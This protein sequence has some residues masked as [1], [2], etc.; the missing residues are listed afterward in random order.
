M[1]TAKDIKREQEIIHMN[2]NDIVEDIINKIEKHIQQSTDTYI[3]ID[4]IYHKDEVFEK[5]KELGF[6]IEDKSYLFEDDNSID[7]D[8]FYVE[9]YIISW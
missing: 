9:K 5:L 2:I 4:K 3:Y 7:C 1:K 6:N 8:D